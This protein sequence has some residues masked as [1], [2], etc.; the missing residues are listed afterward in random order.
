LEATE[1][2]HLQATTAATTFLDVTE[3]VAYLRGREGICS[4]KQ[5]LKGKASPD[6]YRLGKTR[7]RGRGGGVRSGGWSGVL[8]LEMGGTKGIES[9]SDMRDNVQIGEVGGGVLGVAPHGLNL[10]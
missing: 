1:R 4:R 6:T 8:E 10:P 9:R 7:S 2:P 3:R 5:G